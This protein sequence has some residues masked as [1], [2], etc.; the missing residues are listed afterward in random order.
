M[1]LFSRSILAL[2][3]IGMQI[4]KSLISKSIYQFIHNSSTYFLQREHKELSKIMNYK[5]WQKFGWLPVLI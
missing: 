2:K 5:D 1:S 4:N 3:I